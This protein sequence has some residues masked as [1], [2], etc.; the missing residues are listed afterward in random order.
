MTFSKITGAA[1]LAFGAAFALSVGVAEATPTKVCFK[2]GNGKNFI[3]L[4]R[5]GPRTAASGSARRSPTACA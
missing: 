3:A 5:S 4:D 2:T 1:A